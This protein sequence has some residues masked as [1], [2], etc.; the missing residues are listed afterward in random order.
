MTRQSVPLYINPA[1]G[2]GRAGRRLPAIVEALEAAGLDPDVRAS[3]A[4]G[5]I[6][7]AVT[8]LADGSRILLAGGD[9]SVHELVNGILAAGRDVTFGVIPAGT[10]N[11][12]AKAVG[13]PLDWREA[14]RHAA[15]RIVDG[16]P[17]TSLDAGRVN[18]RFFA[19][20][21][22]IGLDA[23]VNRLANSKHLPIGDLVYLLAIVDAMRDGIAT[24]AMTISGD[25]DWSGPVTLVSLSNG[26]WIG[27]LFHMAPTADTGDGL[28]D[29][30]IAAPVTRRRIVSLVPKL[31]RGRHL[32][33]PEVT[34]TR[35]RRVT[36]EADAPLESHL[37]G[38]VQPAGARFDVEVLPGALRLL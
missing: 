18:G 26:P 8:G 13:I 17:P 11:D 21:A 22:G 6:E 25:A 3:V 14:C 35:I 1:A 15:R 27:G 20:G 5:E 30:L 12:V 16:E 19:N 36:I 7:S 10:G 28:L 29:L 31:M 4:P 33:A 37:D 34:H 9:G 32:D 2:R 24:P 38:E 23:K